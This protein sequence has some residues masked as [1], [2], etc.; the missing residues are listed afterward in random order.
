[1]TKIELIEKLREWPGDTV[2]CIGTTD[3]KDG[4]TWWNDVHEA[5]GAKPST[6]SGLSQH[7]FYLFPTKGREE[8]S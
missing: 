7:E 3:P 5:F 8:H 1:M 4:G 6:T 2:I